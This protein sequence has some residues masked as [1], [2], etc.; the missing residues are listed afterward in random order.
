MAAGLPVVTTRVAGVTELVEEGVSGF[1]AQ[2]G[3]VEELQGALE[4]ALGSRHRFEEL[5][6]A[7]RRRVERD[8]DIRRTAREMLDLFD[9]CL[10]GNRKSPSH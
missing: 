2:P 4:R 7:G 3:T 5:G 6:Q 1:L 10:S 8:F 9:L